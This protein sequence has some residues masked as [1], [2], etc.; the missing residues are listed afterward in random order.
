MTWDSR[1]FVGL[2]QAIFYFPALLVAAYLLLRKHGRP[3]MA[4]ISLTIFCAVRIAG[5]IILI[6][7]E[8]NPNNIGLT[9]VAL[10][11]Q[12][13]GVIPLIVST[14]GMLRIM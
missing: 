14:L 12:G 2:F 11:F 13:T 4:W 9:I 5:G 8:N 10:I 6:V 1:S 7:F 3:R